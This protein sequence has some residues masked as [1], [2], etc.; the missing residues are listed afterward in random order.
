MASNQLRVLLIWHQKLISELN[1]FPSFDA[2]ALIE[3]PHDFQFRHCRPVPSTLDLLNYSLSLPRNVMCPSQW[4]WV[5]VLEPQENVW[6]SCPN[7][8]SS[9]LDY[10]PH[11]Q[12][13][14]P[15]LYPIWPLLTLPND[16]ASPS[17]GF[18]PLN[19]PCLSCLQGSPP[20]VF[21]LEYPSHQAWG[22]QS[23]FMSQSR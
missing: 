19:N 11:P 14:F 16:H 7:S 12:A 9:I 6:P 10:N 22:T 23:P 21:C 18:E 4:P 2:S 15:D 1:L 8:F 3:A 17:Q 13:G 5:I 20:Y